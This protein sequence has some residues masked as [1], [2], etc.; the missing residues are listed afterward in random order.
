MDAVA[1]TAVNLSEFSVFQDHF[2]HAAAV[3]LL[4]I[5]GEI[6]LGFHCYTSTMQNPRGAR[7]RHSEART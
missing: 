1:I 2:H 6:L 7:V 3:Q 4:A 5:A